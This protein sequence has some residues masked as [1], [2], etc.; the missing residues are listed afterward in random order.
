MVASAL[1]QTNQS[2][3]LDT[4]SS[5]ARKRRR[6]ILQSKKATDGLSTMPLNEA[7]K[8]CTEKFHPALVASSSTAIAIPTSSD[9]SNNNQTK[10]TLA[11]R[12]ISHCDGIAPPV[13]ADCIKT[14]KGKR[15]QMR[16][17]PDVP[18]T[19]EEAAVWRREQRRKR[20]RESAAASR[21]RQR[22]RITE[23][24]KEVDDWKIK[25]QN[26][27]NRLQDLEKLYGH[28]QTDIAS[29]CSS[30]PRTQVNKEA[31]PEPVSSSTTIPQHTISV[32]PCPSPE[33]HM[34]S[35][36]E[37]S[38]DTSQSSCA[39]YGQENIAMDNL[40]GA[41]P[42]DNTEQHLKEKNSLPA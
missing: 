42:M 34:S 26:A 23:L 4:T 17:E 2:H 6:Q 37:M 24:E 7:K 13:N 3:T 35:C 9:L 18:M 29:L 1:T 22:D 8:I 19:K 41:A 28:P 38:S 39:S 36:S 30:M 33:L 14:A 40:C 31:E 21:Q 5:G 12:K 32:S 25:F 20:N 16:Y 15:P 27:I 10:S 11:P